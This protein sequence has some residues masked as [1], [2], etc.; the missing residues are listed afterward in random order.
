[1]SAFKKMIT[2]LELHR[3]V[4]NCYLIQTVWNITWAVQDEPRRDRAM[5]PGC[6]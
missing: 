5:Y 1:M 6:T 2:N 3:S 4:I